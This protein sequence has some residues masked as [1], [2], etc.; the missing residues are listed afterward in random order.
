MRDRQLYRLPGL[1]RKDQ[2]SFARYGFFDFK[3]VIF[4]T[5]VNILILCRF[6]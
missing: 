3:F 1:Y 6:S 2:Y 5:L 4:E